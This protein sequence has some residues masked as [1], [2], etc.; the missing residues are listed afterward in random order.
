G[1]YTAVARELARTLTYAGCAAE[2]IEYAVKACAKAFGI[3]IRRR[4]MSA[5]TVARAIDEGGKYGILQV[6]QEIMNAPGLSDGTTLHGISINSRH[7]TLLVPSYAPGVDDT[8]QSTWTHKTRFL[9]VAP[10]LDHT[11]ETQF[12]G[13]KAL[14]TEIADTFSRSPLAAQQQR[15]MDKNDYWRK[16]MGENKDHA[17]D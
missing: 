1:Q 6:G 10:E 4:F 15:V 9:E 2:K 14:A 7:V 12:E 5:R 11:A 8:D 16:K 13:T 17:A 3:K